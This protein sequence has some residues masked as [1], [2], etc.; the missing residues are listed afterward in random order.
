MAYNVIKVIQFVYCRI[1]WDET[2]LKRVVTLLVTKWLNRCL[3]T[4]VSSIWDILLNKDI[5]LY[6]FISWIL[7]FYVFGVMLEGLENTKLIPVKKLP[8]IIYDTIPFPD[9]LYDTVPFPDI[10]YETI[11]FPNIIYEKIPLPDIIYDKIPFPDIIYDKI[12]F[13][14]II[15]DNV[16]FPNIIYDREM[17][18]VN[19]YH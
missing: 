17:A 9:I 11:P 2:G 13:P 4:N 10:I 8:D 18:N 14:D 3:N 5:G 1:P 16:P 6:F 12:S 7:P 19:S 15:Y